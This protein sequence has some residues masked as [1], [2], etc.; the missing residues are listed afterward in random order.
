[1]AWLSGKSILGALLGGYAGVEAAKK[2]TGYTK[3]TGDFFAVIAPLGILLGRVG[4]LLHGCCPGVACA[5]AWF[6]ITGADGNPRWPAVPSEM[7][8]NALA[9]GTALILRSKNILPGQHFHLYLMACG[10][11]RFFHEFLRDTPR[12]AGIFSGYQFAA[13]AVFL[14]GLWGFLRR[15]GGRRI[16]QKPPEAGLQGMQ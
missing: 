8:F 1:M 7:A 15:Q 12:I 16:N 13:L 4:C 9:L 11:F 5:P 14:L 2:L 3:P 6:T 10:A